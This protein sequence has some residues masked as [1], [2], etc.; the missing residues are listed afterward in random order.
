MKYLILG[1]A[2]FLGAWITKYILAENENSVIIFDREKADFSKLAPNENLE[3]QTG[4]FR[5]YSQFDRLIDDC[6]VII[7]L[8]STTTPATTNNNIAKEI[9]ENIKPTTRLLEACGRTK[10]K[11][12][13]FI[14][15][16]G[17]VYGKQ[18][19][20][21][22]IKESNTTNPISLYGFQKLMIEKAI[23]LFHHSLGID[24]KILRLSNPYGPFQNPISG[25]GVIS[26]FTYRIIN[27][28]PIKIFGSGNVIR[29]FIFIEDAISMIMKVIESKQSDSLYN[30][31]SGV[32]YSINEVVAIIEQLTNK[33]AIIQRYDSR[34]YD[35]PVNVLDI[36]KYLSEVSNIKP[37]PINEGIRIL[38][39]Y[40][41]INKSNY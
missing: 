27:E 20:N 38:I 25:Q 7:H 16:G 22:P 9:D 32:G 2:G 8:I 24:Y 41:K 29:D 37:R 26:A 10:V 31:G 23:G 1:G 11:K 28:I 40:F 3:Y 4:D 17:T 30:I 12:F 19:S 5:K 33:K 35:V 13:I 18:E 39:D 14:S 6:D 21:F 36:T 34:P 15:S